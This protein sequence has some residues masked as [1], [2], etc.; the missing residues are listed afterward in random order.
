[1]KRSK[2]RI[3]YIP[4]PSQ[5]TL[6]SGIYISVAHPPN[7][8]AVEIRHFHSP[9]QK[10]G[11][12]KPEVLVEERYFLGIREV[13]SARSCRLTDHTVISKEIKKR[14]LLHFGSEL[15]ILVLECDCICARIR[16]GGWAGKV[17]DA[18]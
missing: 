18:W 11:Q 5:D 10:L 9:I 3:L 1:V 14:F 16:E 6:N 8:L 15:G 7:Y 2:L 12:G 17:A 13:Y 4:N